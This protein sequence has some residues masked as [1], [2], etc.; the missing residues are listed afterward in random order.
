ML[1]GVMSC[2]TAIS[3]GLDLVKNRSPW[4]KKRGFPLVSASRFS[5]LNSAAAAHKGT[6]GVDASQLTRTFLVARALYIQVTP[7][8]L[9]VVAFGL[10]LNGLRLVLADFFAEPD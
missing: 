4:W 7:V 6:A 3:S 1:V 8:A 9:A 2:T 10:V 5:S